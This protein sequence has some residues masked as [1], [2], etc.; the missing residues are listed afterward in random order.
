MNQVKPSLVRQIEQAEARLKRLKEEAQRQ[1]SAPA[2]TR[3][4]EGMRELA[5]QVTAIAT[6][7]NVKPAEV[8]LLLSKMKRTGLVRPTQ[9]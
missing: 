4:S 5:D 6:K 9:E 3:E 2:L 7:H 8:V 1:Q